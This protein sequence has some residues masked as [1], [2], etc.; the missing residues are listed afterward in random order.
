MQA[1]PDR[2]GFFCGLETTNQD[3]TQSNTN[4]KEARLNARGK[5][6]LAFGGFSAVGPRG[7]VRA[8]ILG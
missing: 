1:P 8:R 5:S 3:M 2:R 6:T 4:G 7:S